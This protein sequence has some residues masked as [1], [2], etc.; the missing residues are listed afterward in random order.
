VLLTLFDHS[1][2]CVVLSNSSGEN[3]KKYTLLRCEPG[4]IRVRDICYMQVY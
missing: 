1:V 3:E 2:V 4:Y